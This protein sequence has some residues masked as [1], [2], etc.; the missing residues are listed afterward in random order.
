ML[1]SAYLGKHPEKVDHAV[2]A[3]P[4]FLTTEFAEDFV[5]ATRIR[6]IP[7]VIYHFVKTK[8]ESLHVKG[9]DEQAADDYFSHQM[10]MY[11]GDDHSQAGYRCAG[12]GPEEGG[13]WRNGARAASNIQQGAIDADG[14]I[15]INLVAG[16]EEFTNNVL[17]IASEC[18]TVI[19]V[20]W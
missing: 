3:E 19:G 18:Q 15:D 17:F 6:F 16:V 13:S 1:A 2:L 12:G 9:P 14:N 10:N 7:G 5:E 20:E 11:Q 4:G 8:F